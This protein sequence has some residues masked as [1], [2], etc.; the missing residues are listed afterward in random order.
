VFVVVEGIE[1][2]GKSTLSE[3]LA[4]ALQ[5]EGHDVLTT[6]EPGG[7]PVSDAIRELFL[8][9]SIDMFALTESL[10][11]NAARAQHVDALIRPAL[12]SGRVVICDRFTDSTLA[13][14]GF[15]R[16][17]DLNLLR[18][19]CEIATSGLVPDLTFLLD[20]PLSIARDRLTS[21]TDQ[22]SLFSMKVSG[23]GPARRLKD[24]SSPDRIEAEDEVFHERV[25]RGFLEL[26]VSPGHRILDATL[27]A[28]RIAEQAL[29]EV[30]SQLGM[31]VP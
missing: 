13:Y 5:E 31:R 19:I 6:R 20:A 16:G 18:V 28:E 24:R 29:E 12:K 9:R 10:L 15:G 22:L 21:R 17:L 23:S 8:K 30:R 26:A 14:Q 2:S 11:V 4:R 7:T 25:R 3:R 1:S 27:P